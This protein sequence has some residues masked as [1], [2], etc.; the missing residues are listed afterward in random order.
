MTTVAAIQMCSSKNVFDN[1]AQA[2]ILIAQAA[3]T[4]AKLIA[5]PEM[6]A[7]MG[8]EHTDK[9]GVKEQYGFGPIQDF[10]AA[11]AK[12]H[13]LWIVAGTIPIAS[14]TDLKRVRA[15]C[16]VYNDQGLVVARYDKIHLFDIVLSPTESYQESATTEPGSDVVVIDTPA[17]KVGLIVCYDLR[18]PEL[19]RRLVDA[20]AELIIAPSAFAVTTGRVHWEIL[21]RACALQNFCYVI[22]PDQSGAHGG[23]RATQG[24]SLIVNPWGEIEAERAEGKGVITATIDLKRLHEIRRMLPVQKHRK[25]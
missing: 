22:A 24:H 5:L 15:A 20:G 17:G 2:A 10:L 25:L 7:I 13:Q 8:E 18:F 16:L 23:G 1:L 21:V 19:T 3:A 12:Q 6:F 9:V 4:G 14:E 11:Q